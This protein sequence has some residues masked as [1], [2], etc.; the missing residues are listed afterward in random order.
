MMMK[1]VLIAVVA[2]IVPKVAVGQSNVV[3]MAES[4]IR[5]IAVNK[6]TPVYPP[7]S[8]ARKAGG[9]AV[10]AIASGPDGRV[11]MVTVL[12]SPDAATGAAVRDALMKWEIP[13]AT[14]SGRPERYGVAGKITFYFQPAGRGRVASPEELPGGPKPEPAGGPP[15]TPPGARPSGAP[16]APRAA[17]IVVEHSAPAAAEIG[18]AEFRQLAATARPIVL[19]IRERDEFARGHRDGALNIP[20]DELA[21][22][23]YLELDRAR[24]VVIDCSRVE[25]RACQHA[26][27]V[28]TGGP[29]IARVLMLLP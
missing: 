2:A 3:R 17:P 23:G 10:A 15:S 24:P 8:L 13:P 1:L 9:V 20:R 25:T 28:L 6:P 18:E 26:A 4:G 21:V 27:S 14:V 5:R 22:R 7:E 11:S 12:E 19:D 16:A 29:K